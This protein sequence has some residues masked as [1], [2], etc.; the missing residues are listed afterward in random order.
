MEEDSMD[1]ATMLAA[2]ANINIDDDYANVD[3]NEEGNGY[4]GT[5]CGRENNFDEY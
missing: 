3:V 2:S 1:L 4:G 5:F